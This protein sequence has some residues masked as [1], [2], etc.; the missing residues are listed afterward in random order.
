MSLE[1][2][3]VFHLQNNMGFVTK[4]GCLERDIHEVKIRWNVNTT[5]IYARLNLDPV[6]KAMDKATEA[7]LEAVTASK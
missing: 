7:M 6:R 4:D 3:Y 1:K 5:A 2:S